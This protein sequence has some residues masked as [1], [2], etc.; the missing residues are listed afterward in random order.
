MITALSRRHALALS[1]ALL[2]GAPAA[3]QAQTTLLN[4]SYDPTRELYQE[5]NAAFA[6]HWKAKTGKDV[7]DQ[8]VARRLR[9]AGPRRHRRP[10]SRRGDAGARLRRRCHCTGTAV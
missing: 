10:R 5:F 8:A 3:A 2:L 4:V 1:A 9:Q 7:I 6:K